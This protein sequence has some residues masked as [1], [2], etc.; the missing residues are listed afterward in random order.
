MYLPTQGIAYAGLAGLQPEYGLY[1]AFMGGFIYCLLG[2]TNH[3]TIGPVSILALM[4]GM[5][6]LAVTGYESGSSASSKDMWKYG[7]T[8]TIPTRTGTM[9]QRRLWLN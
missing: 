6:P 2:S 9:T 7:V 8:D 1:S 5:L 4:T 3:V